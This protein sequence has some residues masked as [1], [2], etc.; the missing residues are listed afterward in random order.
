M[1]NCFIYRSYN[2]INVNRFVES[3]SLHIKIKVFQ[4]VNPK[5]PYIKGT[6]NYLV[7]FNGGQ[8]SN[9][10]SDLHDLMKST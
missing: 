9:H 10:T 5:G 7:L 2:G 1:E 6:M 3:L 8:P 4:L